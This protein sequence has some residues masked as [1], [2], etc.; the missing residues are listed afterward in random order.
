M[1]AAE[2]STCPGSAPC[3]AQ[4]G[5]EW[6][7]LCQLSPSESSARGHKLVARSQRRVV[8]GRVPITWHSE[9]TLQVTCCSTATRTSPAHSRAVS[10]PCPPP[11][12]QPAANGSPSDIAHLPAVTVLEVAYFEASPGDDNVVLLYGFPYGI[13]S[14][15]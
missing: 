4:A 10:A 11:A 9:L 6:C 3:R 1:T 15:A 13:H 2:T 7:M 12:A 5:S 14:S 8:N